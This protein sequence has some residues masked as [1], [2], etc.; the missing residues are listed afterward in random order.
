MADPVKWF[1]IQDGPSVPWSYMA[2]HDAM[3]KINHGQ[4]LARLAERG[5]LGS[6][7]AELIVTAQPLYPKGGEWDWSELKRRWVE[8]A[9]RVNIA[10]LAQPPAGAVEVVT[11]A[12]TVWRWDDA[13]PHLRSLSRHGGDEDWLAVLPS[14]YGGNL[15]SW[16]ESGTAFGCCDVQ[17]TD[18]PDGTTVVIGAH[19]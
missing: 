3:A 10:V 5:G 1:P 9:E 6:A 15:P 11:H 18:M 17:T 13:P 16:M 8:R 7:E 19:A 14:S 4:T 12:I 2:P